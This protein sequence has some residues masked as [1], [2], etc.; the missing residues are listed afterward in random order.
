[1]N[2][3]LEKVNDF[4]FTLK[5]KEV[6]TIVSEVFGNG[7]I[8]CCPRI[9]GKQ[10]TTF[11]TLG[12]MNHGEF[13]LILIRPPVS[14]LDFTTKRPDLP[15]RQLMVL[16]VACFRTSSKARQLPVLIDRVLWMEK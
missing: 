15:G 2:D 16:N 5:G 4:R 9:G 10:A 13:K 6:C 12:P 11:L 3:I 8:V 14:R 1:L 7:V